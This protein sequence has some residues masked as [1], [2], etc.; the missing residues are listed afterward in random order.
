V[1]RSREEPVAVNQP[2]WM[3]TPSRARV[4]ATVIP[5]DDRARRPQVAER[6][7]WTGFDQVAGK[8]G[9]VNGVR[10]AE[11]RWRRRHE[12]RDLGGVRCRPGVRGRDP[13][14]CQQVVGGVSSEGDAPC[15]EIHV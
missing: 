11:P 5:V 4:A 10:P 9:S 15:G 2:V 14:L 6:G 12:R 7:W 13:G 3:T 8:C 1:G